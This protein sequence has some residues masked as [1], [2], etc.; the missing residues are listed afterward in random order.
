MPDHLPNDVDSSF[1]NEWEEYYYT[2]VRNLT[3]SSCKAKFELSIMFMSTCGHFYCSI[4]ALYLLQKE[5][6]EP[7][8]C[9]ECLAIIETG[10]LP[11]IF[12]CPV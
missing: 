5:R 6:S 9:T 3:G 4:C 8:E 12:M 7:L 11:A 2:R 10:D 1:S